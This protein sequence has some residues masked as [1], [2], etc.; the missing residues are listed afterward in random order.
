M[1]PGRVTR[2]ATELGK[3]SEKELLALLNDKKSDLPVRL[4]CGCVVTFPCADLDYGTMKPCPSHSNV[5]GFGQLRVVVQVADQ[6]KKERDN[7]RVH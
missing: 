5:S 2:E 6:L 1:T 3:L 7:A 4:V